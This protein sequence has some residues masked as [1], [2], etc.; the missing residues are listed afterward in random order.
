MAP[1]T[2]GPKIPRCDD[3]INGVDWNMSQQRYI[4]NRL[5]VGLIILDHDYRV[6]SFSGVA[7][8]VIGLPLRK[9]LGKT[10]QSL[11]PEY[12]N[13]KIELML[14][15]SNTETDG[16]YA[17]M[18]INMPDTILQLRIVRLH[19]A[20]G[21]SGYSLILHDITELASRPAT[22]AGG[23]ATAGRNLFKLPVSV[24]GRIALLDIED[25]VY[26]RAEGHYAQASSE[27]KLFFCNMSLSQLGP[28]LPKDRFMRVHRSYIINLAHASAV[29]RHDD[30]YLISM[31]GKT[32]EKIPVSRVNVPRLRQLLGV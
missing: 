17:S 28:R 18:L 21:V 22:E 6:V 14:K 12:S 15:Q 24:Q 19:D 3:F 25:V 23:D 32:E 29:T 30:Q 7:E 27:G 4:L 16:G 11:H 31:A 1:R 8:K 9:C 10:V 26:L 5:P 2:A 13:S 20:K